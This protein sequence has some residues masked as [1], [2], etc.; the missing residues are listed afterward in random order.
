MPFPPGFLLGVA[1]ASLQVEGDV[2]ASNWHGGQRF[3]R[4]EQPVGR[5]VGFL[6]QFEADLDRVQAMGLNAFRL[7]LEWSRIEPEPGRFDATALAHYDR[8]LGACRRRGL[9]PLVTLWHF[10]YPRWLDPRGQRPGLLS[11]ELGEH[12]GRYA[13][14][15]AVRHPDVRY[16]ITLNE[17]NALALNHCVLGVFPPWLGPHRYA[18]VLDNLIAAHRAGYRA[19]KDQSPSA[20]VSSNV[21]HWHPLQG[22]FPR[23]AD[24]V[25]RFEPLDYVAF[26]YYFA[27][28]WVDLFSLAEQW[29]WPVHPRGIGDAVTEYWRRFRRPV[30]I[31]ENGFCTRDGF[32]RADGWTRER[33]LVHHLAHLEHAID[34]GAEVLGYM[35]WSLLDNWEWGSFAP[36]FGLYRVD[37]A[38]PALPRHPTE[39]VEI[40]REIA[41]AGGVTASLRQRFDVRIAAT[42]P[43]G[44]ARTR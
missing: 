15:M 1:T 5:A 8:L 24:L 17:P 16:W 30:L 4:I 13:R 2:E 14:A 22:S 28:R 19:L 3:W 25:A 29:R 41:A 32:P 44:T 7:S 36:R 18:A 23:T 38:D 35:H 40:F 26:D 21:F 9:E 12:F 39:S 43:G 34:G 42:G 20:Q 11:P 6:D 37:Y 27:H 31:A 10:S 33:F